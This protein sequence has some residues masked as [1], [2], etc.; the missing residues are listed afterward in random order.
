MAVR[1]ADN[2][3]RNDWRPFYYWQNDNGTVLGYVSAPD[4]WQP[5]DLIPIENS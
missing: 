3:G 1:I 5:G 2:H 4:D